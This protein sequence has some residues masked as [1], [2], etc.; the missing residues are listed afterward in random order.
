MPLAIAARPSI[1][2][3]FGRIDRF[4]LIDQSWFSNPA[5]AALWNRPASH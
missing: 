2:Y 3:A 4:V 5:I 1:P